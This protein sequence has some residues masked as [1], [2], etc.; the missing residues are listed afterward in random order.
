MFESH[1]KRDHKSPPRLPPHSQG[2]SRWGR[3]Q[4]RKDETAATGKG[5]PVCSW[6]TCE[7]SDSCSHTG[8]MA[9]SLQPISLNFKPLVWNVNTHF[10]ATHLLWW[11]LASDLLFSAAVEQ[12]RGSTEPQRSLIRA[13][14]LSLCSAAAASNSMWKRET[15][16]T[17]LFDKQQ[18]IYIIYVST[19]RDAVSKSPLSCSRG[20]RWRNFFGLCLMS[21]TSAP[22]LRNDHLV[23]EKGIALGY[24]HS[25]LVPVTQTGFSH[26][27]AAS[28]RKLNEFC[29]NCL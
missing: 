6:H 29:F 18:Q 26:C 8:H 14:L 25:S 15:V 28:G 1:Q 21:S 13:H 17:L 3:E 24:K 9:T 5:S 27:S 12:N 20:G 22:L 11:N 7:T 16:R 2:S 10:A 19:R 23:L 4:R